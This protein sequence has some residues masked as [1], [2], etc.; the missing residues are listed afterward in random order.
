[1][2]GQRLV[3]ELAKAIETNRRRQ[4]RYPSAELL[5][6][7]D[8]RSKRQVQVPVDL[9]VARLRCECFR[10]VRSWAANTAS[11]DGSPQPA[12]DAALPNTPQ[13]TLEL[14]KML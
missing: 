3:R 4:I 6:R 14:A 10:R 8:K 5:S 2:V 9:R 7:K 1:M 12:K 11:I 13:T